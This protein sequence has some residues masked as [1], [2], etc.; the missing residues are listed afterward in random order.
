PATRRGISPSS[1]TAT[2]SSWATRATASSR[3]TST[4]CRRTPTTR[5]ASAR[6]SHGSVRNRRAAR[7]SST[8]TTSPSGS[9][10][11]R[12]PPESSAGPPQAVAPERANGSGLESASSARLEDDHGDLAARLLLVVRE[13]GHELLLLRPDRVAL[14]ALRDPCVHRDRVVADLDAHVG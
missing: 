11:R 4:R 9:P 3:S 12:H 5:T 1:S 6:R 8:R 10:S 2:R 7:S 13:A 14:G